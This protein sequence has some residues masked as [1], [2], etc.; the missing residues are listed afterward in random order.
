MNGSLRATEDI[1]ATS[2]RRSSHRSYR[3]SIAGAIGATAHFP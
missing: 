3:S 1:R 2:V